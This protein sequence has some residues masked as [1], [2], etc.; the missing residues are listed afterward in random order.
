MRMMT[1]EE[2][3][4]LRP[5]YAELIANMPPMP[6]L[7]KPVPTPE[8]RTP[9]E[10]KVG[11]VAKANPTGVEVRVT[12]RDVDGTTYVQPPRRPREIVHVLE[13]DAEGRPKRARHIDCASGEAGIV[14]YAG[15]YQQEPGSCERL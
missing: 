10:G 9:L 12:A 14:E 7:R 1:R 6:P 8:A 2:I 4:K 15:G 11:E 5:H 13:V 3:L